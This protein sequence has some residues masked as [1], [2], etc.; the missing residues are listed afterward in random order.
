MKGTDLKVFINTGTFAEYANNDGNLVPAYLYAATKTAFRAVVEYYRNLRKFKVITVIPYTIYGAK[1]T[2]KKL[3]DYIYESIYSSAPV[4]MSPGEQVLD[5]IHVNDVV[6]F[7]LKAIQSI[8]KLK[9]NNYEIS[10]GTGRGATP[11][12]IASMLEGITSLK[13]NINWG[14]IQYR[15]TDTMYSISSKSELNTILNWDP[16]IRLEEGLRL[17]IQLL[18]EKNKIYT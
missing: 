18:E 7:Y 9:D 14:G 12:Q 6:S 3:V 17:Y 5:F 1:D 8:D 15:A 10:L 11:K 4:N 16:E 2:R 13:P